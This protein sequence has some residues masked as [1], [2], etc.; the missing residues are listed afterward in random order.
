MPESA[1]W[2]VISGPES[3]PVVLGIDF[4]AD[5][6]REAGFGELAPRIG[7]GYRFMQ[8]RPP[9]ASPCQRLA[10]DAYVG[11]WIEGIQSDRSQV[12]AVLGYRI[13]GVYAALIAE[14]ISRWQPMPK[15]ILF[16]PQLASVRH[17][18]LEFRR[19]ISS[20]SSLLTDEEIERTR[21]TE[22]E[23]SGLADYDITNAAVE[24]ARIYWELSSLAFERVGLGTGYIGKFIAPFD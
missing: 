7:P 5:R 4:P 19:E 9:A 1:S 16:D 2:D 24:M 11:P 6:R 23:I 20:I 8:T 21:R 22:A 14:G 15:V 17:L 13:G 18:S 10:G 3:G 12:L